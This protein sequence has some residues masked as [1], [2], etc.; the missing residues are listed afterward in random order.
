MGGGVNGKGEKGV[1][2]IGSTDD[3][4]RPFCPFHSTLRFAYV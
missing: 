3:T 1:A 2:R 4:A